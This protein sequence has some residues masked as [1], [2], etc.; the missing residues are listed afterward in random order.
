MKCYKC[1][2]VSTIED[3][4]VWTC[5]QHIGLCECDGRHDGPMTSSPSI[6]GL[7]CPKHNVNK[8]SAACDCMT[9]DQGAWDFRKREGGIS[10]G[11]EA[12]ENEMVQWNGLE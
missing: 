9:N 7:V 10:Y 11:I 6:K 12:M 8:Y 5:A 4:N 3:G 2:S 1:D